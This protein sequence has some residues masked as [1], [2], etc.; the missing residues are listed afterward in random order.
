MNFGSKWKTFQKELERTKQFRFKY[1]ICEFPYKY[2]DTFPIN[3]GIPA[4][5]I[6]FIRITSNYLKSKI[7]NIQEEYGIEFIFCPNEYEAQDKAIELMEKAYE[8]IRSEEV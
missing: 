4:G 7:N 5:K 6:K 3:S 1:I 2:L 8:I